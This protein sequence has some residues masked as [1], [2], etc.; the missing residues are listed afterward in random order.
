MRLARS[1]TVKKEELNVQI[2]YALDQGDMLSAHF[3]K[4]YIR[5]GSKFIYLL[6]VHG[7]VITLLG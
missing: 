7:R 1:W 3:H 2:S 6:Y 5:A 4:R